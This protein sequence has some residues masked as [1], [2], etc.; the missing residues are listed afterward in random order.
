[1]LLWVAIIRTRSE[2][3]LFGISVSG[4][5]FWKYGNH[6]NEAPGT[7]SLEFKIC[8]WTIGRVNFIF[9][10]LQYS[11][12]FSTAVCW[13]EGVNEGVMLQSEFSSESKAWG[14]CASFPPPPLKSP[15]SHRSLGS[16]G[17]LG[18]QSLPSRSPRLRTSVL[19]LHILTLKP[20][21][22]RLTPSKGAESLCSL[23][24]WPLLSPLEG[25]LDS[26]TT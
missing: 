15:P 24:I 18:P 16:G 14:P 23:Y 25:G 7:K 11:L 9:P 5:W 26:M 10:I 6:S 21:W 2:T 13:L 8:D 17:R 20:I 1:M 4:F 19:S 22:S 3:L 12:L